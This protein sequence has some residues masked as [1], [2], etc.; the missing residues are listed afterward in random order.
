MKTTKGGKGMLDLK[1]VDEELTTLIRP[2]T[3]PVAVKL[4]ASRDEMPGVART[5]T[6]HMGTEMALCQGIG[7]ARRF[8]W[9]V[10]FTMEDTN[11]PVALVAMGFAPPVAYLLEGNIAVGMYVETKEAGARAE[12][13]VPKFEYGKYQ[14]IVLAPLSRA[15][16]EPDVI[17]V[18]GNSAQVMR[19]VQ[20][21]L[22]RRGGAL[23]STMSG[24]IDCA[25]SIVR[26]VQT[27]E[28]QV[29]LPCTGDRCYGLA[30]D[31]EMIFAMP[32]SR[33]QETVEGV[34]ATHRHGIRYPITVNLRYAPDFP[35]SYKEA[36]RQLKCLPS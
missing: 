1:K 31:D 34:R 23:T 25:D 30:A 7:L 6:K 26:P 15:D 8:G 3:F 22:Y 21:A 5:P 4:L 35:A 32:S 36:V 17:V 19:L 13:S 28:C 9:H 29:V 18:Y 16:F 2:Q 10:G 33:V 11:C 12:A 27:Q 14:A 20:G 24:R